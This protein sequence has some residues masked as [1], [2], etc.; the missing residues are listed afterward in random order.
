MVSYNT[1]IGDHEYQIQLQSLATQEGVTSCTVWGRPGQ[2]PDVWISGETD[3]VVCREV[4]GVQIL[5]SGVP[6][7]PLAELERVAAG[8]QRSTPDRFAASH[9]EEGPR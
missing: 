9:V 8:M 2:L 3:N 1:E 4:D 5:V 7:A 6:N